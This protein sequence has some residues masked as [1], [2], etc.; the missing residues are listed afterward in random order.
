MGGNSC[1]RITGGNLVVGSNEPGGVVRVIADG[2]TTDNIVATF[3]N[4]G[5]AIKGNIIP[6]ANAVYSLGNSTNY[7]ANLWVANNTIYIGG[8]PLGMTAGNV[9][10]VNGNAVLTNGSNTA[11]STT[12]NITAGNIGITGGNLTWANA[13]IVQTS[14]SDLSIT[15]DG[16]VTVR[17]L[18][19]TYQWTF[20]SNGNLT[21]PG[22]VS[23]T[24]N[25]TAGNLIS[26]TLNNSGN[27]SVVANGNTWTFG[28]DGATI[29]P[30][31]TVARGDHYRYAHRSGLAV[32]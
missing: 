10:T 18:D 28:T 2:S 19:G 14:S 22:N 15:G 6:V 9:L 13:S 25:I 27:I 31:L 3:S 20:D 1:G 21:A 5:M 26:P 23:A 11:I 12:G 24:G 4:V 16:Q 30:T 8:V 7:W 17:S 29:F 32:W